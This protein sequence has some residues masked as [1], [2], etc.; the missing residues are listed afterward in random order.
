MTEENSLAVFQDDQEKALALMQG[1]CELAKSKKELEDQDKEMRQT[2]L[3][4]CSEYDIQSID[5]D[6]VKI[7]KCKGSES[8]TIDLKKMQDK[9]PDLYDELLNDYPKKTVRKEYIRITT[10][11]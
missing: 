7:T 2:L 9:E 8:I 11:G 10:K 4:L 3:D 1:I 6:F 5:N